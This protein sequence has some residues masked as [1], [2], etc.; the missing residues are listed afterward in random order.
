MAQSVTIQ[1]EQSKTT[2]RYTVYDSPDGD[3]QQQMVGTYIANPVARA[4]GEFIE[5]EVSEGEG[6]GLS[7]TSDKETAS[8]VVFSSDADAVEATYISHEV[9]ES[10]GAD[11][12][13]T[14][15]MLAASS[16]EEAFNDALEAQ[17]VTED[18]QEQEAE[19]LLANAENDSEQAENDNETVGPVQE[20]EADSLVS[21]DEIGI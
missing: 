5:V 13:S 15:D 2:E 8:F 1:A 4:L 10:I 17:T 18:E 11:A 14:I 3:E 12:D 19:A 21:N 20:G 6:E 9:L 7:L 16:S